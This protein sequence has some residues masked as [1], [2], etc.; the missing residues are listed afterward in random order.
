MDPTRSVTDSIQNGVLR[1]LLTGMTQPVALGPQDIYNIGVTVTQPIFTGGRL[2]HGYRYAR[3]GQEIQAL[4]HERTRE[5]IGLAARRLFWYYVLSAQA[6][7]TAVET[8]Q[9]FERLVGDQEKLYETGMMVE[10]D[11]LNTK[12]ELATRKLDELRA[13][14]RAVTLR[15]QLLLFLDLPIDTAVEIDTAGWPAQEAAFVPPVPD[16]VETWLFYRED[17]LAAQ[18]R[19][20]QAKALTN[21]QRAAYAPAIA[22]YY[23]YSYSNQYSADEK[24]LEGNASVGVNLDWT[25]FDWGKAHRATR[26]AK[27]QTRIAEVQ[28]DDLRKRL[29][30][31]MYDLGRKV[32]ESRIAVQIA[33]EAAGNARRSLQTSE[34]RYEA[35]MITNTDLLRSRTQL[36]A[37]EM[38]LSQARVEAALALEEYRVVPLPAQA[39][40]FDAAAGQTGAQP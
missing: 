32:Q 39:G 12:T 2:V 7:A 40:A 14:N 28:L 25:I 11:L 26:Q 9:W 31:R 35:Q 4:T 16:S 22:G 24:K 8:R 18:R 34:M 13:S 20:E 5:E 3:L 37:A 6:L 33:A 1:Y 21:I 10:L 19:V 29:R 36:T 15:E 30:Q 38:R 23:N 17:I 27:L